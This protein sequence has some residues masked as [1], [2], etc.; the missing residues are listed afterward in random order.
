MFAAVGLGKGSQSQ[1]PRQSLRAR[2]GLAPIAK[3]TPHTEKKF[4][5]SEEASSTQDPRFLPVFSATLVVANVSRI[6]I[7]QADPP[8]SQAVENPRAPGTS[9]SAHSRTASCARV[10]K[11]RHCVSVELSLRRD[12]QKDRWRS[13]VQHFSRARLQNLLLPAVVKE[14]DR[15]SA[16]A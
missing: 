12:V 1:L 14:L 16:D 5:S 3:P 8:R 7:S 11:V 15:S 6:V 9:A 4:L 13:T 10:A 2:W